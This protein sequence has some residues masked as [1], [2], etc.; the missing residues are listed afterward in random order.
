VRP[1]DASCAGRFPEAAL[2]ATAL[3]IAGP[4]HIPRSRAV[5]I[6]APAMPV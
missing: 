6:A 2:S 3:M 5:L 4:T 1:L